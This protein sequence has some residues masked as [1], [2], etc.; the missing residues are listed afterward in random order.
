MCV[1][2]YN[3]SYDHDHAEPHEPHLQDSIRGVALSAWIESI[4]YIHKFIKLHYAIIVQ[5][6][7]CIDY[8]YI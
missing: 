7:K 4:F 1:D 8:E 5:F 2:K 3:Y 6:Y